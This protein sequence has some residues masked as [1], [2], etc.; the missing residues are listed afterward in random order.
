MLMNICHFFRRLEKFKIFLN[1]LLEEYNCIWG[2]VS[3]SI[4]KG[5]DIELV[6]NKKISKNY[7]KI[8]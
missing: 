4:K 5:F 8:L 1:E 3:H 6:Y 7:N 2:K